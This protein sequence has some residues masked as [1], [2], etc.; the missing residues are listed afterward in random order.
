M[1]GQQSDPSGDSLIYEKPR[2]SPNKL[3]YN[4]SLVVP[5]EKKKIRG[6]SFFVLNQK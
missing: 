3:P 5:E 1:G 4:T 2:G 6:S